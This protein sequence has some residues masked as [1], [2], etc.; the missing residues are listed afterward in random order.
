M[1]RVECFCG[2]FVGD[3]CVR[4]RG[5]RYRGFDVGARGD[6]RRDGEH[7]DGGFAIVEFFVLEREENVRARVVSTTR[8]T[9]VVVLF[10]VRVKRRVGVRDRVRCLQ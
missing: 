2:V 3:D 4:G 5:E 7:G 8:T 6:E 1:V 10:L 9:E